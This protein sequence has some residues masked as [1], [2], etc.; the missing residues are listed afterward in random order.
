MFYC[1]RESTLKIYDFTARSIAHVCLPFRQINPVL[2][3]HLI[4][5]NTEFFV[6]T[7]T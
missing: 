5:Q 1:K 2:K 6:C 7:L 4:K 3:F